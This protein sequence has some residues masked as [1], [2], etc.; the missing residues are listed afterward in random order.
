MA[1]PERGMSMLMWDMLTGGAPYKEVFL[2]ALH[3]VFW[4]RFIWNIVASLAPQYLKQHD[5]KSSEPASFCEAGIVIPMEENTMELGALGKTYEPGQII[6]RQGEM[7][8][9]MYVIQSGMVE[10]VKEVDD[11]A[12]QLATLGK[13]EFFGEMAIFE[14]ETRA[15]TV[16]ATVPARIITIDPKNLLGR[17]QEDPSLAYHLIQVMSSRIRKSNEEGAMLEKKLS[18]QSRSNRMSPTFLDHAKARI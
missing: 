9:C 5:M 16:R 11:R 3:P 4:M 2:R 8:D 7:G 6:V 17:I 13:G 14:Q 1:I 12:I 18:F 10:V 15:A